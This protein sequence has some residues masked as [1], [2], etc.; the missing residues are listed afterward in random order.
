MRVVSWNTAK[1]VQRTEEQSAYIKKF[2]ADIIALQEVLPSSETKW[3]D[4]LSRDY[5]H[6]ISSFELAP[7]TAVLKKKRMFGQ[8]IASKFP[9]TPIPPNQMQVPWQE[10]VLSV[11]LHAPGRDIR[12][13][14]TH[15]PPGASNGWIKIETIKGIVENPESR[16]TKKRSQQKGTQFEG[17]WFH[18]RILIQSC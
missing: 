18:C 7:D 16:I 4:Q 6:I 17:R 9:L 14:T 15:I 8:I 13:L 2:E 11:Q 12:L 1:R 5:A 10:R 3:R